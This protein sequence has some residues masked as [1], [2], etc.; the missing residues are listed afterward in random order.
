MISLREPDTPYTLDL[1]Y[2]IQVT[3][4]PLT[5]SSMLIAQAKARQRAEK[6]YQKAEER[7]N[8]GLEDTLDP[9]SDESENPALYQLYLLQELALSHI[10]EWQGVSLNDKPAPINAETIRA[11]MELYPLGEKFLS[12]LTL[13][14]MLLNAAKKESGPSVD[15]ISPLREAPTIVK[16]AQEN[17]DPQSNVPTSNTA[18]KQ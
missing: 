10:I 15:G 6:H 13:K 2:G 17:A 5:T 4:K 12:E 14:Q 8:H 9:D 18:L 1:A 11:V 3:V 16:D 7:K